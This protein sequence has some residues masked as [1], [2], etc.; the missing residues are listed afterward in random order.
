MQDF[1]VSKTSEPHTLKLAPYCPLLPS[2]ESRHT[3][4]PASGCAQETEELSSREKGKE[5]HEQGKAKSLFSWQ[6]QEKI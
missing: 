1:C 3:I 2:L 4:P 6:R 5:N